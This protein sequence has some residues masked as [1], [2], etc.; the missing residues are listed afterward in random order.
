MGIGKAILN[1]GLGP[2]EEPEE[3]PEAEIVPLPEIVNQGGTSLD[4]LVRAA[5]NAGVVVDVNKGAILQGFMETARYGHQSA[6]PLECKGNQCPIID[7]CPLKKIGAELPIGKQ[8]PVEAALIEQWVNGYLQSLNI[9][10]ND[11]EQAV[12]MHM[13]YEAAGLELIRMRTAHHLS[14]EGEVVSTKVV[15][16]SPQG[17]PIYDDKPSMALLIMERQSKTMSKIREGLLATRK[18]Q[19]QVGAL[20]G[21]ISVKTANIMNKAKALAERRRGEARDTEFKV[22][23]NDKPKTSTPDADNKQQPGEQVQDPRPGVE[24]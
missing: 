17:Q 12:D 11:P 3:E 24:E 19:A 9:D 5:K 10:P 16:Y 8:C 6:L 2:Q 7:M 22:I 4:I 13:V 18:S 20:A 15:G 21:D 23:E 14:K 1:A